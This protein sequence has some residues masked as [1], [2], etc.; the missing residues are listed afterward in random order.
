MA[1]TGHCGWIRSEQT[2]SL[3]ERRACKSNKVGERTI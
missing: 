3:L 1:K 2:Q